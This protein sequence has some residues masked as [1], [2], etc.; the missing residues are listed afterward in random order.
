MATPEGFLEEV[1]W[2]QI[3]KGEVEWK[4]A[5]R[6]AVDVGRGWSPISRNFES[7]QVTFG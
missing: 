1:K 6:L 3:L 2:S 5:E 4:G 7:K